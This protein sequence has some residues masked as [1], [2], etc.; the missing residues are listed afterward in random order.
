MNLMT[1]DRYL[2]FRLDGIRQSGT[3]ITAN[4]HREERYQALNNGYDEVAKLIRRQRRDHLTRRRTSTDAALWLQGF[5]YDPASFRLVNG[6]AAYMLPPDFIELRAIRATTTQR[7]ATRF[8]LRDPNHE[9]FRAARRVVTN[10][11][12]TRDRHVIAITA[13]RTMTVAPTPR[14]TLDIEITYVAQLEKLV[15]YSTGSLHAINGSTLVTAAGSTAVWTERA[16]GVRIG[17]ELLVGTTVA[18]PTANLESRYH[19]IT[20]VGTA[21]ADLG[22][23]DAFLN[24]SVYQGLYTIASVPQFHDDWHYAIAEYA[25]YELLAKSVEEGNATAAEAAFNIWQRVAA[26]LVPDASQ[27]Q[28]AD[29]ELV[30]EWDVADT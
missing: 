11:G 6:T 14:E 29:P 2:L 8:E 15:A 21:G 9:D 13:E 19:K 25:V 20:T 10:S 5:T 18:A 28:T 27:R 17:D 7:E 26:A 4:W 23:E 3:V 1:L 30:E 22:L 16:S 12:E 24:A